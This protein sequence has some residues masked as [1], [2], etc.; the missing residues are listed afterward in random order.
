MSILLSKLRT[1]L[2]A[3]I[4]NALG[5]AKTL[6]VRIAHLTV[7]KRPAFLEGELWLILYTVK[8]GLILLINIFRGP[9]TT[10]Y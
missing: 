9:A 4:G 2:C 10:G 5:L 7:A 8:H 3:L 1:L 6:N